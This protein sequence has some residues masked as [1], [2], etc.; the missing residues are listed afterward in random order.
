MGLKAVVEVAVVVPPC[1]FPKISPDPCVPEVAP[2]RGCSS[3][4]CRS[5]EQY[6]LVSVSRGRRPPDPPLKPEQGSSLPV[7]LGERTAATADVV[8]MTMQ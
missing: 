6:C 4:R 5:M 3:V 7:G 8:D 2:S 1:V